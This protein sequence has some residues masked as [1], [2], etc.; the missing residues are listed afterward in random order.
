MSV[1]FVLTPAFFGGWA[2][3]LTTLGAVCAEFGMRAIVSGVQQRQTVSGTPREKRKG[4]LLDLPMAQAIGEVL[5]RD[6]SVT[7]QLGQIKLTISRDARGRVRLHL[8]GEGKTEEELQAF[9]KQ[10][11]QRLL[12]K[13]AYDRVKT[14]LKKRGF[15]I[16]EEKVDDKQVIRLRV[17]RMA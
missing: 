7:Y 9:G 12:Q 6:Q 17:R 15:T 8:D 4:L 16:W 5:E 11:V 3:L 14:E 10:I 2:A 1:I 13:S